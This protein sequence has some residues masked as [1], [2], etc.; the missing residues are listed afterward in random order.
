MSTPKRDFD[1]QFKLS[2]VK[3][4]GRSILRIVNPSLE[5]QY[6]A[7]ENDPSSVYYMQDAPDEVK[8]AAI[9]KDGLQL[10]RIR[11]PTEEMIQEAI[12]NDPRVIYYVHHLFP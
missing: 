9:Q 10:T 7:I 12:K 2:L 5:M 11:N 3:R 1:Y 6:A 8:L 4:H